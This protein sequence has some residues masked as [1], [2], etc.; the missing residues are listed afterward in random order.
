MVEEKEGESFV[1]SAQAAINIM[2]IP[3]IRWILSDSVYV[4]KLTTGRDFLHNCLCSK[5][6]TCFSSGGAASFAKPPQPAAVGCV[7]T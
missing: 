6:V 4:Q 2:Q 7:K 5:Y 3:S 1:C